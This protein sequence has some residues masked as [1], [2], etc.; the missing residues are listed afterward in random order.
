MLLLDKKSQV[1]SFPDM[2]IAIQTEDDG[3][4]LPFKCNQRNIYVDGRN[5]T[6]EIIGGLFQTVWGIL[7]TLVL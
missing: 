3:L 1:V 2:V 6:R 7:P 5:V 4:R